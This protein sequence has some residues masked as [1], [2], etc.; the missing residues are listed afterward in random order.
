M[1]RHADLCK[2]KGFTLIEM[3]IVVSIIAILASILVPNFVRARAQAQTAGCEANLKEIATALELY[4]TDNDRYPASGTVDS[5]NASLQPYLKQVPVDPVA[6]PASYY[7]YTVTNPTASTADYTIVCPG[8]HDPGTLQN[9][10]PNTTYSHIQ[11]SSSA[12][13]AATNQ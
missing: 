10:T 9:I 11:Y 2:Q 13:F 1:K 7:S 8:T 3:M 12:G 4:E 5:S 6:G